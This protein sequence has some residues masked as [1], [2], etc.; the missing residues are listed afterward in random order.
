ML[1]LNR[2][3]VNQFLSVCFLSLL[4]GS[5]ALP[6]LLLYFQWKR[7]FAHDVFVSRTRVGHGTM[8]CT[9]SDP[10]FKGTEYLMYTKLFVPLAFFCSLRDDDLERIFT[11]LLK[12]DQ[13]YHAMKK[14]EQRK[15]VRRPRAYIFL[16]LSSCCSFCHSRCALPSS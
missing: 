6:V 9:W 15:K 1:G 8:L 2:L 10:I 13:I 12:L 3:V 16:R 11:C 4:R 14:P 7:V 5:L